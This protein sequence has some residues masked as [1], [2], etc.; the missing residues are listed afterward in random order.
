MMESHFNPARTPMDNKPE[1]PMIMMLSIILHPLIMCPIVLLRGVLLAP[2]ARPERRIGGN[3]HPSQ[4]QKMHVFHGPGKLPP[5]T[6]R[7]PFRIIEFLLHDQR[8]PRNTTR[9]MRPRLLSSDPRH[10]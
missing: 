6:T 4:Q 8:F 5:S 9:R 1:T 2:R 7:F 10:R 3:C